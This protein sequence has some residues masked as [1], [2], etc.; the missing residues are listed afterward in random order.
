VKNVLEG[1]MTPREQAAYLLG[2]N[3]V[4]TKQ[5]VTNAVGKLKRILGPESPE[6]GS[7][8]EEVFLRMFPDE[9]GINAFV[10]EFDRAMAKTPDVMREVFNPAQLRSLRQLRN[11]ISTARGRVPGAVN[12]SNTAN[13]ISR[14]AQDMFGP[15]SRVIEVIAR[16][17]GKA[18]TDAARTM[19]AT[20]ATAPR[21]LPPNVTPPG[22]G[23]TV[24]VGAGYASGQRPN[25][26]R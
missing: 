23:G 25:R 7:I 9:K 2:A 19:E 26:Q 24:G 8:R 18:F 1:D 17:F 21:I 13:A 6:F 10:R 16:R 12:T 5:G 4:G 20:S 3:R 11:V 15:S 22:I 14:I